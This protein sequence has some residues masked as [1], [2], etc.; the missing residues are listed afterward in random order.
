LPDEMGFE[1]GAMI[2]PTAVGAHATNRVSSLK[3]KNVVVSGAGTIGNLVAQFARARGADKILI[4][5]ISDY[6]LNIAK[7][8][9]FSGLLNVNKR[10]FEKKVK[11]YFGDKGFNV[12]FEAAGVQQSLEV[13]MKYIEK[14][15]EIVILGVYAENP[16]VN[17]YYLGEHELRLYGSMMYLHEDYIEALKA[18]SS[19]NINL[20]PLI[21]K[22]FPFEKYIEAYKFI[23]KQGDRY[24][25]II[26]EM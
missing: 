1:E 4:T 20:N 22:R 14:G 3:G 25:K 12:G 11:S 10:S 18:I 7:K 26:I 5:D 24:M 23:E 6:R 9:G 21:T 15:S 13:L 2:E 17:M 8:C 19:E 16:R